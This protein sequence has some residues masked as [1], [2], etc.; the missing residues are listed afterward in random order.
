MVYAQALEIMTQERA[1]DP[2]A[3]PVFYDPEDG[4]FYEV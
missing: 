4:K 1:E 2:D 3:L